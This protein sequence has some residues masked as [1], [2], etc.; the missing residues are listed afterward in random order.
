MAYCCKSKIGAKLILKLWIRVLKLGSPSSDKIFVTLLCIA[1]ARMH[2][3]AK[4]W[5]LLSVL[6]IYW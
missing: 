6:V 3:A 1:I 5:Q 2:Y 4:Y